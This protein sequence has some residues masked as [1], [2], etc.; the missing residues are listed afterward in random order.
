VSGCVAFFAS[1]S[2]SS[3]AST[4]VAF[5][6]D[7]SL[8]A[9]EL[10]AELL[11]ALCTL[12]LEGAFDYFLLVSTL[13]IFTMLQEPYNCCYDRSDYDDFCF[14][15]YLSSVFFSRQPQRLLRPL[16]TT[17][18]NHIYWLLPIWLSSP[19]HLGTFFSA[20]SPA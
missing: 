15:R 13:E 19:H 20:L 1:F 10:V 14:H 2:Y 17:P 4:S 3:S 8:A 12:L 5:S 7:F 11:W 18:F 6:L 16:V 9:S